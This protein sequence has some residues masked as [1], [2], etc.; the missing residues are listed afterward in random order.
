M[1]TDQATIDE[2]PER[3]SRYYYLSEF[4]D[5]IKYSQEERPEV[6]KADL[7]D[8]FLNNEDYVAKVWK[9][10]ADYDKECHR[11]NQRLLRAIKSVKGKTFLKHVLQIMKEC[12][13]VID[14]MHI[15]NEPRGDWQ[16]EKYGRSIK[17][18][19]VDQWSTGT[20]GDSFDG[21]VT[22][23]L[24]ENMYLQFRYSM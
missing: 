3:R 20:E 4:Y 2:S 13:R 7:I 17:G 5:H 12:D 10:I 9:D 6:C 8:Q 1:T 22:I 15:V 11:K 21:Y 23:Q 14:V 24:K 19:W 16:S 18:Y